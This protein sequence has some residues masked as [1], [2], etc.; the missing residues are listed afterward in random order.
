VHYLQKPK[1]PA[2]FTSVPWK[3]N[4][5]S[6][7]A[8]SSASDLLSSR[9]ILSLGHRSSTPRTH[10]FPREDGKTAPERPSVNSEDT[11]Q[12]T[13]IGNRQ[14]TDCPTPTSVSS[15]PPS[16]SITDV[17]VLL[18]TSEPNP[19]LFDPAGSTPAPQLPHNS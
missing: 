6:A 11:E 10:T 16:P 2:F 17:S 7:R 18:G 12:G 5:T 3:F 14:T 19:S 13:S 8:H 15:L 9:P 4:M 1:L